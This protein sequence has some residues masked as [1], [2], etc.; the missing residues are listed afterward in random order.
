MKDAHVKLL[1]CCLFCMARAVCIR[2]TNDCWS[3]LERFLC[4]IRRVSVYRDCA[5]FLPSLNT[6]ETNT[7]ESTLFKTFVA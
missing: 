1:L 5:G 3:L 7:Q 4:H 2:D 6:F